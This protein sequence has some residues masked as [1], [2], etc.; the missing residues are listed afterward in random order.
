MDHIIDNRTPWW[1]EKN[2]FCAFQRF[3]TFY[4]HFEVDGWMHS[5]CGND[6]KYCLQVKTYLSFHVLTP[7][8]W[9]KMR[10]YSVYGG[11]KPKSR[12]HLSPDCWTYGPSSILCIVQITTISIVLLC[13]HT[14]PHVQTSS[15]QLC[16]SLAPFLSLENPLSFKYNTFCG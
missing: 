6:T 13:I 16:C 2:W 12:Y 3:I 8:D 10:V 15:Y 4:N 14:D 5:N 9:R 7:P 1:L 11:F